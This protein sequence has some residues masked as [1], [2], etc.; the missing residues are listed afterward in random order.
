MRIDLNLIDDFAF[1]PPPLPNA[2]L[3]FVAFEPS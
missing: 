2:P 1:S 3:F